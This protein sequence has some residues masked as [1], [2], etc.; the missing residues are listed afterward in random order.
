MQVR[1][2]QGSKLEIAL[3]RQRP[4]DKTVASTH[5]TLA[6]ISIRAPP[7]RSHRMWPPKRVPNFCR[8]APLANDIG[9]PRRSRDRTAATSYP[10]TTPPP[11]VGERETGEP[12]WTLVVAER[13]HSHNV[14]NKKCQKI[15]CDLLYVVNESPSTSSEITRFKAPTTQETKDLPT[16]LHNQYPQGYDS[17]K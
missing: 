12:R 11:V 17:Q 13:L 2:A 3:N 16:S 14:H 5:L 6:E 7:R 15:S 8:N 4:A 10:V 9:R 1:G